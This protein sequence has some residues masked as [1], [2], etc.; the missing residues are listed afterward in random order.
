MCV[1]RAPICYSGSQLAIMVIYINIGLPRLGNF[2]QINYIKPVVTVWKMSYN[3]LRI[4][5]FS[6]ICKKI[7]LN[8][9]QVILAIYF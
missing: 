7:D 2:P 1:N 8:L 6:N 4:R 3:F 9:N 5:F